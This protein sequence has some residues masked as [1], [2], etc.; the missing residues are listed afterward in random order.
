MSYYEEARKQVKA[1]KAI[2][3]LSN[4]DAEKRRRFYASRKCNTLRTLVV[5]G[6]AVTPVVDAGA[7]AAIER[8]AGFTEYLGVAKGHSV[9]CNTLGR[10]ASDLVG[11]RV[12]G[13][14][15][16][17]KLRLGFAPKPS[18]SSCGGM[19]GFTS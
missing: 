16:T 6:K 17:R 4:A 13:V 15:D 19:T 10:S 1:L 2:T 14:A 8:G 18:L 7:H 12:R 5:V 11:M 9:R 3:T